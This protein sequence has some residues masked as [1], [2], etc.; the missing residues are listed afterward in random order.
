MLLNRFLCFFFLLATL[1]SLKSA[2]SED[3]ALLVN[4]FQQRRRMGPPQQTT[5]LHLHQIPLEHQT[6][7]DRCT[8]DSGGGYTVNFENIQVIQLIKFISQISGRNF[9]FNNDDVQFAITIVSEDATPVED[10]IS[11]LMQILRMRGLSVVE[12]G[13]NIVLYNTAQGPLSKLSTV[14]TDESLSKA[15]ETAI[16]TRV[17]RLYNISPQGIVSIIRPLVSTDAIVDVSQ[18]TRHLIVTDFTTNIDKIANLLNA[19]DTPNI[20]LDIQEYQVASEYP[21]VLAAYAR[22]ILAPLAVDNPIKLIPQ[23]SSKKIFIVSTPYLINRAKEVLRSLD[24]PDLIDI[25]DLPAAAMPN[26][27]FFVYKLRFQNGQDIAASVHAVGTNLQYL[28]VSNVDLINTIYSI[29][30]V[31]VNN[32]IIISGTQDSVNKVVKLIEELDSQPKQVYIE[33]LVIDTTI[34]NSLDFGVQWIALGDEQN[35]LA[36]GTGLTNVA[37][38]QVD[39]FTQPGP[40]SIWPAMAI[41]QAP[42]STGVPVPMPPNPIYSAAALPFGNGLNPGGL[43]VIP[44]QNVGFGLGIV[45][46]ILRHNGHSFLTL[47]ALVSALEGE[48]DTAI[49][50]NPRVMTEDF[51][52]ANIFIGQ[53]IPYQTTSTIIRDTG[54]VTQNIQYEDIG[55][56]L[57]V[58]PIISPDN[59]VTLQIDQSISDV[60][61]GTGLTPTTNKTLTSTRV[62]IPDG[63]FLVM[64][65]HIRDEKVCARRGIPCLGTLPCIGPAF[66]TTNE[67]RRKRN[68]I[69]FIRPKVVTNIQEGLKLTNQEGYD[70]NW[71]SHPSA[72]TEC[73][74]ERAPECETY[75]PPPCPDH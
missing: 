54:S 9:V 11:A 8:P 33:V 29:E 40:P 59:M 42:T 46:N 13:N 3:D 36:Y 57:L 44:G 49:V 74:T 32:S 37:N 20:G 65:G 75:P 28:G 2:E 45:G 6:T 34:Q 72:I 7:E 63:T 5:Q 47:G 71:E 16:V 21:E 14:V 15:C 27:I 17:F 69:L 39:P 64:S 1:T 22:D 18:E 62:H 68:L 19:L 25:E 58:T 10:L 60:V 61:P 48:A 66:S 55:V 52:P 26:N 12:Q 41:D 38:I 67:F 43:S 24:S 53:N 70:Y 51:Q 73:T 31:Q 23:L 56:Q 50:L 4:G 35:K 30:W